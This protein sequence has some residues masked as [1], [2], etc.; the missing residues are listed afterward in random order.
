M[1]RSRTA[2]INPA[3]KPNFST[4]TTERECDSLAV[5]LTL[6]DPADTRLDPSISD[7][8]SVLLAAMVMP[9]RNGEP[10]RLTVVPA[11]VWM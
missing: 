9:A 7:W 8:L 6:S 10:P 1:V 2:T 4:G 11:W 3:E 5:V